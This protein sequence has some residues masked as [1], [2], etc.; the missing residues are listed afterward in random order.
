MMTCLHPCSR[1]CFQICWHNRG[2]EVFPV[3]FAL[4]KMLEK[5][6]AWLAMSLNELNL[7]KGPIIEGL[8]GLTFLQL[9]HT[10]MSW[11][12]LYNDADCFHIIDICCF[13]IVFPDILLGLRLTD[14]GLW[15][16]WSRHFLAEVTHAR[17]EYSFALLVAILASWLSLSRS[18]LRLVLFEGIA[19]PVKETNSVREW[20]RNR[21]SS[22]YG[23]PKQL[24]SLRVNFRPI[25]CLS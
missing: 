2:N 6:S 5:S 13:G 4:P 25:Q 7:S 8:G 19:K 3:T 20:F 18:W 23:L 11:Y 24:S 21:A 15:L 12:H 9:L 10:S 14:G 1:Y 17:I 16:T 22:V